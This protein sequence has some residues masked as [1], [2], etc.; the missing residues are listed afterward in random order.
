MLLE[1]ETSVPEAPAPLTPPCRANTNGR[2]AKSLSREPVT[3]GLWEFMAITKALADE[4]R[5]RLLLALRGRELCLCQ[6]VE[7]VGLA[8]STVSKHMSILRQSRLVEGRKEGRWM[9]YRLA[10]PRAT[11]AVRQAIDWVRRSLADEP[12][13]VRDAEHLEAILTVDAERL[14]ERP[15]T[16]RRK[17]RTK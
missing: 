4:Q 9:Y 5:V 11:A 3:V 7:L 14:C 1:R 2:M 8:P 12:G 15:C 16:P 13:V 10:G 6:L 17:P